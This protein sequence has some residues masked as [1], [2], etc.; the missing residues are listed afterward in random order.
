MTEKRASRSGLRIRVVHLNAEIVYTA[1]TGGK[2]VSETCGSGNALS[3]SRPRAA[4]AEA[5]D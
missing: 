1:D 4:L 2:L 5:G 3:R